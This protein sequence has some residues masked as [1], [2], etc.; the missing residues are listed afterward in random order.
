MYLLQVL[1]ESHCTTVLQID[2]AFAT[3]VAFAMS[4]IGSLDR[5]DI[6]ESVLTAAK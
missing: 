5:M 4:C 6:P 2:L 1:I 3:K